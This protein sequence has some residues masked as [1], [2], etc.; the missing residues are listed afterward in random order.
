VNIDEETRA[1]IIDLRSQHKKKIHEIVKIVEIV[2]KSS[3]DVTAVLK[4]HEIQQAQTSKN[5]KKYEIDKGAQNSHGDL[6][7]NVKAYKLLHEGKSPLEVIAE[8]SIPGPQV[9]RFYVEYLNLRKMHKVVTIYQENKSS[10]GYFL[11]LFRL[12]KKKG[13]T[14]EQIIKLIQWLIAFTSF[15]KSFSIYKAK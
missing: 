3:R 15:K 5:E 1:K 12:G 2:G 9:Q 8:L 10:I 6:L 14:P 13:V 4:K 11:K 7:P